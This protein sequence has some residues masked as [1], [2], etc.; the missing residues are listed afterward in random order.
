MSPVL[1]L[2][3]NTC[4]KE[5]RHGAHNHSREVPF[6]CF[7]VEMR[8][9]EH[10]ACTPFGSVPRYVSDGSVSVRASR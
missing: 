6:G 8:E 7:A 4:S 3:V 1:T 9:A 2:S 10:D 5:V